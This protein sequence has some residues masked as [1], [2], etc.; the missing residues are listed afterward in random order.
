MC[1]NIV[2]S[3]VPQGYPTLAQS[4]QHQLSAADEGIIIPTKCPLQLSSA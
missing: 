2:G 1:D 3:N 4:R